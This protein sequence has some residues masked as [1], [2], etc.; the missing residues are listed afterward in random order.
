MNDHEML[1]LVAYMLDRPGRAPGERLA[2]VLRMLSKYRSEALTQSLR[3]KDAIVADGP[4]AGLRL[5]VVAEGCSLP[6]LLGCYEEELHPVI[7]SLA[8]LVGS[9]FGRGSAECGKIA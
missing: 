7:E 8:D 4:F 6:K 1:G 2:D 9:C 3:T 5:S